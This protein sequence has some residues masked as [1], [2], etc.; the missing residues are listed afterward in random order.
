MDWCSS[1][2]GSNLQSINAFQKFGILYIFPISFFT[3]FFIAIAITSYIFLRR[4]A[5]QRPLFV[6]LQFTLLFLSNAC[7]CIVTV[8]MMYEE[9]NGPLLNM[10]KP[11]HVQN[12]LFAVGDLFVCLT[13]WLLTE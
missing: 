1:D 3:E 10:F 9:F 2:Q 12:S 5:S 11:N 8:M 13:D 6:K 4:N 7:Y